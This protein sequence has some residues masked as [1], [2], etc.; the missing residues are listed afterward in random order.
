M[1][2][3]QKCVEHFK[4]KS[5]YAR[6]MA[7][8]HKQYCKYGEAKGNIVISEA[9]AEKCDAANEIVNPKNPFVPP[10]VKFSVRDFEEGLRKTSFGNVDLRYIAEAYCGKKIFTKKEVSAATKEVKNAVFNRVEERNAECFCEKWLKEMVFRKSFGYK[11][12]I[13]EITASPNEAEEMLENV[14]KAINSRQNTEPVQLAVL[15]AEITGDSHYFDNTRIAGKLLLKGLACTAGMPKSKHAEEEKA[16]YAEFGIEPDN[17]SSMTAAVGIRLYKSD[18]CEHPAFKIFAD[19]GEICLIAMA[20]LMDIRGADTDGKTVI[21]VE[22]PMV[23]TAL[24]GAAFKHGYGLICTSGQ[25]K[26]SGI[27]LLQ[28]LATAGCK[29]L[30]AGD[31]DPEGLQIADKILRRFSG[32][33]VHAWHMS[34]DD[35]NAIEKGD[36]ITEA[37]LNK[38]S[39][40]QSAELASAVNSIRSERRAAYQELLV[41]QMIYDI[42]HE[43]LD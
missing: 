13:R 9:S 35:Y 33:D 17:I 11:S 19:T 36:E 29:I 26:A 4:S 41:S 2:E 1:S 7:S 42:S 22:N 25:L 27:K 30:Y 32:Y 37:R 5:G 38:L 14:C 18:K 43:S 15:S 8:I 28:M 34:A 23:F 12:I 21:A 6:I 39:S 31:F 3:T 24:S 40:V 16:I 10:L 20:N